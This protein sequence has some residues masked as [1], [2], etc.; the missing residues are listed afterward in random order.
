VSTAATIHAVPTPSNTGNS[1]AARLYLSRYW[2][3]T[4]MSNSVSPISAQFCPVPGAPKFGLTICGVLKSA[5]PMSA[6]T[7]AMTTGDMNR[8]SRPISPE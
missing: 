7:G 4:T 1:R 2:E 3:K 5:S 6:I 8:F